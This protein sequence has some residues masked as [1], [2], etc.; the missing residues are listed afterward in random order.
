M[1]KK[2]LLWLLVIVNILLTFASVGAEGFFGW[3]L[4]PVLQA[5]RQEKL[6]FSPLAFSHAFR[7]MF[8]AVTCLFAF[9][10]WIGLASFWRH[11]RGLFLFS[12]GLDVVLRLMEGPLVIPSVGAAFRVL[13]AV[14]AGMIIGLVYFSDLAR[15]FEEPRAVQ[16]APA[17][18]VGA[19]RA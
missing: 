17:A 12:L 19:G 16:A 15:V 6:G 10:S 13:D 1:N 11:G 4:P 7:L 5:Y 2:Q 8:L 3:T 9:A 14:S 18:Q